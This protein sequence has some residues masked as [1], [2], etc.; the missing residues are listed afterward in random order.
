MSVVTRDFGGAR[1]GVFA[2]VDSQAR[3][4]AVVRRLGDAIEL[5]LLADGE[6]LPGESDLAARL[7]VSTVTL[8]EAL[9]ALRQQGLVTTRRGRGGGSFVTV[10][11]GPAEERLRG[12]LLG[13]STEEL[14]DLGDH[15]A[16]VSG[17]AARLAAHRTEPGDLLQLSRSVDQ[18][19]EASDPPARSRVHGRF[20]VELAA[21]AQS[22]RLTREEIAIQ[23]EVGALLSL[24]LADD[25][26]LKDV[27]D[28]H[29]AVIC[30]LQDDADEQARALAEACVQRCMARLVELRLATPG[31]ADGPP[32]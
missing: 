20:H 12:L 5:G 21:A 23:T 24:V 6:Q 10:P 25:E 14:R 3:V 1:Q 4:D 27:C 26:Y 15:W 22:A 18:L 19:A 11:E 31:S 17:A 28:R 9:M 7:S 16:A 30:A 29:R 8:R 13:W 2:P 32:P